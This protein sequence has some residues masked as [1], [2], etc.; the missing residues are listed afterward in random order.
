MV[1]FNVC[2]RV[3]GILFKMVS[4]YKGNVEGDFISNS[5]HQIGFVTTLQNDY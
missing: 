2:Y 4:C 5:F 3:S 1:V